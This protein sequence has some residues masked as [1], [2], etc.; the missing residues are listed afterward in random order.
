MRRMACAVLSLLALAL[1]TPSG[2]GVVARGLAAR[3]PS[4]S[5][6]AQSPVTLKV[7]AGYGEEY[8]KSAWV[9]VRV[10][11]H[12]RS[13]AA[14]RGTVAIPDHGFSSQF[15]AASYSALY[16]AQ[17]T[18]SPG[19]SKQV[20]LYLPGQH[21]GDQISVQFLV[22]GRHV[23]AAS[24]APA[25]LDDRTISVGGLSDDPQLL[26]WLQ[27]LKPQYSSV[28]V[29]DLSPS[30]LDPVPEAL[31]NFD[32][33]VLSNATLS[34]DRDQLDSLTGFVHD[35]GSLI[36][37]G[38]PS[39]Q[40]T[41]GPLPSALVP[42]RLSG[43]RAVP[44]LSGLRSLTG[45]PLDNPRTKPFGDPQPKARTVVSIL[46]RPVGSVL[47]AQ[48]G[49]PLVV[50]RAVGQ[51][52]VIYLAFDPAVD[53]IARWRGAA[54]LL[55]YLVTQTDPSVAVRLS[56]SGS[57]PGYFP[58]RF[59]P[60]MMRQELENVP[61]ATAPSLFLLIALGLLS[62]LLLGPLNLLLLRHFRKEE[63]AW[64]T[65]PCLA[66]LCLATTMTV[67]LRLK[68]ATMLLNTVSAVELDGGGMRAATVYVGIFAP[69]RGD[70]HLVWDGRGLAQGLPAYSPGLGTSPG[71]PPPGVRVQEGDQT[72]IDFL[73]MNMWSTRSVALRTRVA[74]AGAVRGDLHLSPDGSVRGIVHNETGLTLTHAV[75][76]AGEAVLHVSDLPP[77]AARSIAIRPS[78]DIHRAGHSI[79]GQ[80]Y[81]PSPS[82]HA[83]ASW[84]G[85]P[86]EEPAPATEQSVTDRLRNVAERLPEA[87]DIA[88]YGEILFAG[89][90]QD[91]LGTLSVDGSI[92]RRRDL[93]LVFAPLSVR[94]P[95]GSF[96]L[97]PGTLGAYLVDARSQQPQSACCSGFDT[98]A[99][100][101]ID[102]GAGD[103]AT[104]QFDIP[105][106][107]RVRFRRLTLSLN[108]GGADENGIGRVYDWRAR[109]WSPVNFQSDNAALSNPSRFISPAGAL[110]V[111][112]RGSDA[113]GDVI[114]T[115]PHLDLQLSGSG[116]VS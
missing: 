86:W 49:I 32:A 14:V 58:D 98:P 52:R 7:V 29:V 11:V 82:S 89:W 102:L 90:S 55:T 35:G 113:A 91:R 1:A 53:S 115:D 41:L 62:V 36:L 22:A 54:Q 106:G 72:G 8:R 20:T 77:K 66:L 12:N 18:L 105:G 80:I 84:D 9:P 28:H 17:L 69:L 63:W 23:A 39:W 38:G 64:L 5:F 61:S 92:P 95:R 25:A 44:D 51:G 45:Y 112:L 110:L 59:G 70:Y 111:R 30:T 74:V 42:G 16:G 75:I 48:A 2:T 40:Q 71:N 88:S 81:G 94:F 103:M 31:G 6:P 33:I 3:A 76:V 27:R 83:F 108:A 109:Q 116:V 15:S 67:T 97:R 65:M 50:R 37:V 96:Q 34:L 56:S 93:S 100:G 114:I 107:R 104:F 46:T 47:A 24:D 57:Q 4:I 60:D 78:F 87:R 19:E 85:D 13:A 73:S 10:S 68:G 79:W 99:R 43:S 101:A 21:I 26:T